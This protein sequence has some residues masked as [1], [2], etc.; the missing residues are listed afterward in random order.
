[1]RCTVIWSTWMV[2]LGMGLAGCDTLD[3]LGLFDSAPEERLEG[4]RIAILSLD[5]GLEA[6]T[7]VAD[8]RVRLS[9]PYVNEHWTHYG[10]AP[11]HAMYHLA[12]GTEPRR[13]W[14]EDIGTGSSDSRRLLA[15][16]LVVGGVV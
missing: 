6:D 15:Q 14:S 4:E 12:L 16:P 1:M 3:S 8:M 7:R 5:R 11:T 10:G 9:E 2:A 13:A